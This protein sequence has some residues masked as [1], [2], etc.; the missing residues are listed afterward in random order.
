M[1]DKDTK[2]FTSVCEEYHELLRFV[3]WYEP[4]Y[5]QDI[6]KF[7][8]IFLTKDPENM[9]K[10]KVYK[11]TLHKI[12]NDQN[13]MFSALE[14]LELCLNKEIKHTIFR[15]YEKKSNHIP[16]TSLKDSISDVVSST[17]FTE[18]SPLKSTKTS[19]CLDT[20]DFDENLNLNIHVK[21]L[22]LFEPGTMKPFTVNNITFEQPCPN[23]VEEEDIWVDDLSTNENKGKF[24]ILSLFAQTATNFIIIESESYI[25]PIVDSQNKKPRAWKDFLKARYEHSECMFS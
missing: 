13:K 25:S 19:F 24:L 15:K 23:M 9:V 6:I 1:T 21:E 2:L 12:L 14:D 11:D 8:P 17:N 18:S 20:L 7:L 16:P 4:I 3:E 5:K 10:K 22:K